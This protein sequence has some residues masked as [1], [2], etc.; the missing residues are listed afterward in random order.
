MNR[1]GFHAAEG[2]DDFASILATVTSVVNPSKRLPDLPFV[3]RSGTVAVGE[4]TRLLGIKI[5]P[6]L[7][8]LAQAYGDG[9]VATAVIDPAP[10]Y[11]AQHCGFLPAFTVMTHELDDGYW[12]GLT[13]SPSNDPTVEIGESADVIAVV[14][15]SRRW[16][17]W[18]QRSWELAVVWAEEAGPWLDAG[19]PF[20][21]PRAA[22]EDFA[23][24]GTWGTRLDD[25][26]VAAFIRNVDAF[27]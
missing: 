13:F 4:F 25:D 9:D 12:E 18:G 26:D 8:A 17:V 2:A 16:A 5:V 21:S 22:L 1:L 11:Y 7:Q 3:A 15:S 6:V 19:V 20:V 10:S 14:G 24:Y 23:G 27:S